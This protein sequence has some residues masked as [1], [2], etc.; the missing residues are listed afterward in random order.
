MRRLMRRALRQPGVA[1][2]VLAGVLLVGSLVEFAAS[3]TPQ[4]EW[5]PEHALGQTWRVWSA[6][7]VHYSRLHLVGNLTGLALT[8]AFGWVSRVPPSAAAAWAVAWPFTHLAF[9]WLAPELRHYGGLSGVVHAGVAIVLTHL[10]ITGTR[11]QRAV[12]AAVLAGL[13]AKILTET[14][15]RGAVQH[16]QG[17]DI[18]I[19]PIAH[20][21]GVLSGTLAAL[22]AHALHRLTA[23]RSP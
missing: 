13:V 19:A 17:W 10:F 22:A 23:P 15:W 2:C 20:V 11:G 5:Q 8:A 3:L 9:F 21:T 4:L 16:P 14:P 7:F 18:A 12:A 6:A 1:W